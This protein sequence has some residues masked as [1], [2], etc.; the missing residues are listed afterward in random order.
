VLQEP[1]VELHDTPPPLS[2]PVLHEPP[3]DAHDVP[4]VP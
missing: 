3:V 4:P 1:P 2:S